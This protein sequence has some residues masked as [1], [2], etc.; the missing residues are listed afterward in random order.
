VTEAAAALGAPLSAGFSKRC[1]VCGRVYE[2]DAW[3]ALPALTTLPPASVQTHL[4]IPAGWSVEL[5]GCLCGA[6]LATRS[7]PGA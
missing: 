7:R 5:R 2:A 4:T 3:K 1:G 6:A